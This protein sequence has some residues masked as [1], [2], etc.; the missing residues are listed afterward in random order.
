MRKI[1]QITAISLLLFWGLSCAVNP[2]TGKRELMLYSEEGEIALGQQT[3]Q[4]IRQ[5]Y[6]LYDDAKLTAYVR[7]I[8][9]AMVPY[10]HRPQLEYHF[11]ILD[12][13]VANA[14]AVPGG[15][16]YV[17]RGLLAMMNSEAELAAVVGHELGHVNARHSMRKMSQLMLVQ[18]GLVVGS[19]ISETV[20]DLSGLA[21][22][23]I[24]LLFLKFSRDDE[25]QADQLGVE[26]ARAGRYNP[27]KMVNFFQT[28]KDMGDLSGGQSLPG[29]LS[30]H[31]M[32]K[33]RIENTQEMLFPEDAGLQVKQVPY[34]RRIQNLIFGPDPRQGYVEN[35]V[36]YHPEMRFSF[37]FPKDWTIQNTPAQVTM[38]SK[39]ENA[40]VILQA[41]ESSTALQEF[42]ENKASSLK[43]SELLDQSSQSIN[44]LSSLQRVY[45]INQEEQEDLNARMTFIRKNPYIYTFTAVSSSGNFN[46]YDYQFGT[47]AG[48]F[49]KLNDPKYINR[50]P[51]RIKLVEANGRESLENIFRNA[52]MDKEIWPQF[53]VINGMESGQTP[54]KG[55]L[56]KILR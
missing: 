47:I 14:F 13:P 10:T 37:S 54:K 23:G 1:I 34:L 26:Y 9:L 30:T 22:V 32:Y 6:G 48:S 19:A 35:G 36:F 33:E 39:D 43:G 44:G 15:Y 20:K 24:Q 25:R 52:G 12:T 55:Q 45:R 11:S 8:G 40:A 17:T 50:A 3:D 29:F 16:I 53:A 7:D 4:Q 41:E 31:P 42:A 27:A 49:Q 28:L 18:V 21:S 2:V 38:V 56:I 5:Q 46:Q 51:K